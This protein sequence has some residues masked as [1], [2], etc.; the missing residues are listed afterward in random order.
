MEMGNCMV[1]DGRVSLV[2]SLTVVQIQHGL[3]VELRRLERVFSCMNA[4]STPR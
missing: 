3:V 2:G 4:Q 1:Y